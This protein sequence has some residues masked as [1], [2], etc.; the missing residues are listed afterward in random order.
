MNTAFCFDLDGTVTQDEVLPFL[1]RNIGLF[2]E[3]DALTMATINGHIPFEKSFKLRVR[4][5]SSIPISEVHRALK[6]ISLHKMLTE[7]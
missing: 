4:L 5:L 3:I 6:N 2:D 1:A 7:F